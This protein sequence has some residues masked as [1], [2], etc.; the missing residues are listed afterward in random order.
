MT[1]TTRTGRERLL[2]L[3]PGA[4]LAPLDTPQAAAGFFAAVK[5]QRLFLIETELWP[6]WLIRARREGVPVAV[7]SA[8]LSAG[9]ARRYGWLGSP[10]RELIGSLAAV[11]C[12]SDEDRARW[13][14]LGARPEHTAVAGNLKFDSLPAS[15]SDHAAARA[16]R[17]LDPTRPV[18][19]LGSLRPGEVKILA[20]AWQAL[21]AQTRSRWQVVAVPR[22]PRASGSLRAEARAA[23]V[24]VTPEA[25]VGG[26]WR[27]D[28][29]AGVLPGY[30]AAA[31]VAFVG[32]SL[33]PYGG[34]NPLEPAAAGAAV[35]VGPHA[36]AQGP[37]MELLRSHAAVIVADAGEIGR[38]LAALLTQDDARGRAA[39]AGLEA[40]RSARGASRRAVARLTEWG[41]WP[42]S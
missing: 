12:Q 22:H 24:S 10:F 13:L 17:G 31:D 26:A 28:D 38:S 19:V 5:P 37:A 30:Y 23:G 35:I 42:T 8:R 34:H 11:L 1:A 25:P 3:E 2:A 29:H 33:L 7:L 14:L 20:A 6:Q 41:L 32:G 40:V 36:F 21:D 16:A 15:A 18:L 4:R 9:A 27:W 39:G